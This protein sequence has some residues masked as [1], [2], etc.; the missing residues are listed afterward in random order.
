MVK[1]VSNP[2]RL[3]RDVVC[4]AT[5]SCFVMFA[6]LPFAAAEDFSGGDRDTVHE[7]RVVERSAESAA[8]QSGR[9]T[10]LGTFHIQGREPVA[11]TRRNSIWKDDSG[12]SAS[13]DDGFGYRLSDLIEMFADAQAARDDGDL[14]RAQRLLE[15]VVAARPD[16]RLA[17]EARKDLGALYRGS[18][19][20]SDQ[21]NKV[22]RHEQARS[23]GTAKRAKRSLRLVMLE[24]QFI[25]DVGDRIFF[26]SGSVELDRRAVESL[27]AQAAWL[28]A[29]PDIVVTVEGHADDGS[30]AGSDDVEQAISQAR[31][32]AVRRHLIREGISESRLVSQ[33]LGRSQPVAKCESAECAAQ[34]RRVVT[35]IAA[36]TIRT[37]GTP[38][39]ASRPRTP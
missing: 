21:Q 33:G 24:R 7:D 38:P 14:L 4:P 28:H 27:A 29:H 1:R 9:Q 13:G 37:A 15:R 16:S 5:V 39:P 26:D 8:S 18:S 3:L 2:V 11:D 22:S 32:E 20:D 19:V 17:N 31:A 34:N 30:A 10:I 25:A 36:S 6:G 12:R 35:V 23:K